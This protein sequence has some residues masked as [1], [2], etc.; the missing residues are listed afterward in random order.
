MDFKQ[1]LQSVFKLPQTQQDI[2]K[3]AEAA[4]QAQSPQLQ[5]QIDQMRADLTAAIGTQLTLQF[6]STAALVGLFILAFQRRR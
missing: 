3:L 6:V 5:M 4:R 2:S 1:L